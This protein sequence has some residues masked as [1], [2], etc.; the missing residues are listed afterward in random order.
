MKVFIT[1]LHIDHCLG[2]LGFFQT[3]SLLDAQKKLMCM[4][5]QD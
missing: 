2:L 4:A 3:M 1:H 5:N